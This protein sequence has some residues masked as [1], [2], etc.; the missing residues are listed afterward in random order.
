MLILKQKSQQIKQLSLFLCRF[1]STTG[2]TNHFGISNY[3]SQTPL[4]PPLFLNSFQNNNFVECPTNQYRIP[5]NYEQNCPEKQPKNIKPIQ[6]EKHD[7]QIQDQ[8]E[9]E[10]PSATTIQ[11]VKIEDKLTQ[12]IEEL[13]CALVGLKKGKRKPH[14][15]FYRQKSHKMKRLAYAGKNKFDKHDFSVPEWMKFEHA[16]YSEDGVDAQAFIKHNNWQPT[17]KYTAF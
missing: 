3:T 10:M 14:V 13:Q 15:N 5:E 9:F 11:N 16:I 7:G 17:R 8:M 6:I 12:Q 2:N 4:P 1:Q